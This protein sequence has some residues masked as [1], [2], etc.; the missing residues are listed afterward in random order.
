MP[1]VTTVILQKV[2]A[3]AAT[4]HT[5]ASTRL[6]TLSTSTANTGMMP[7]VAHRRSV[8]ITSGT[9]ELTGPINH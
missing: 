5:R 1:R 6:E 4:S 9:N 8:S 3:M 7:M 2:P